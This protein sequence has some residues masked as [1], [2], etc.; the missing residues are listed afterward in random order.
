ML[1]GEK[2][3]ENKS[4]CGV[5][6]KMWVMA[7][8]QFQGQDFS[9]VTMHNGGCK[10]DAAIGFETLGNKSLATKSYWSETL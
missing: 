9:S 2:K 4:V 3:C 1:N 6:I 7:V 8:Q 5:M 10:K